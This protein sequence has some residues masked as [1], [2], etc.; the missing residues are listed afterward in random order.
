[1]LSP[2]MDEKSIQVKADGDFTI[3]S[4]NHKFNFLDELKR[5]QTLDSLN[6]LHQELERKAIREQARLAVLGEKQSLLNENKM[7]GGQASGATMTQLKQALDFYEI[8]LTAIKEE[9]IRTDKRIADML[10]QQEKITHQLKEQQNRKILPSGEIEIRVSADRQVQGKFAVT[11]LVSHAGW[12]PKYDIRVKDVNSPLTLTYKAEVFQH[13]GVDWKN[14]KLKFSN[15]TPNQTGLM[16][17]LQP[18]LMNFA[19]HTI[20]ANNP[21]LY[22]SRG[23][24]IASVRGKVVD[25]SGEAIPG[26]NVVV[27]GTTIGTVTD[28]SGSYS[29]TLPNPET[30]L[31]F[32]FVGYVTK[33]L[34]PTGSE[35]SVQLLEDV[36]QLSE[37]VVTAYGV[38]GRAAGVQIRG[39]ASYKPT[40]QPIIT[41]FVENQT[42][43]EIEVEDPYTI[44]SNGEKLVVELKQYDIAAEYQYYAVPKIDKDAFLMARIVS[45][46]QYNLLEGEANLYFEDAYVGR[47]L[48]NAKALTDTLSISLGRDKNIV[49]GRVK[50]DQYTQK[51]FI[52]SNRTES[53]GFRIVA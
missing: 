35:M 34:V 21:A 31:V 47:S 15:G 46:D 29:I 18:W 39:A 20:L 37:V 17:E 16:P 49:I 9:E 27:K 45:W 32:S 12:F 50:V 53:R 8:S 43:V 51:R 44:Q 30:P 42:T 26:V 25:Q 11:Y 13:T 3:L 10:K 1:G 40:T 38:T 6:T 22:G 33:E 23:P 41:R 52:G 7:L 24:A 5:D 36:S 2:Y 19:R 14:V 28:G 4:V 48:L